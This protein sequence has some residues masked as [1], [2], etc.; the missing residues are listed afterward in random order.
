MPDETPTEGVVVPPIMEYEPEPVEPEPP[1]VP[2]MPPSE[3]GSPI[4]DGPTYPVP[5][6]VVE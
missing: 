2:T 3:D 1:I 6:E 5:G 4:T